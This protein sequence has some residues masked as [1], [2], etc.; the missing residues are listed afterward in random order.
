[1]TRTTTFFEVVLYA[2]QASQVQSLSIYY[3]LKEMPSS[4]NVSITPS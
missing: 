1:L 2:I 4:I 3:E